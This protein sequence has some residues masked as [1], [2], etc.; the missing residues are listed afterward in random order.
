M[1]AVKNIFDAITAGS[2]SISRINL[3]YA[4]P[5]YVELATDMF[6]CPVAYGQPWAAYTFSS[7]ILDMPL[8][9]AD[10]EAFREAE[11]ICQRELRKLGAKSSLANRVRRLM[12]EWQQGFPTLAATARLLYMTPRTLHRHLLDEGTSFKQ[13]LREVRHS[14]AIEHLKSGRLTVD[15]IARALGY[16]DVANFRRAFRQWEGVPP[17]EYVGA[18]TSAAETKG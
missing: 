8:R 16:S 11:S 7:S 15:D 5:P 4:T 1:L 12:L 13:L 2:P 14:L 17:S 9:M 3:P 10:P 6:G 18:R